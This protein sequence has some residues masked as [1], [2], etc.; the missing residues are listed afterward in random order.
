M[1]CGGGQ[2]VSVLVYYSN[3]PS[4]NPADA[5]SYVCVKIVFEKNENKQKRGRG[6]PNFYK[7]I[8]AFD[9]HG[10]ILLRIFSVQIYAVLILR[11]LIVWK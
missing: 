10:P 6:W 11:V 5:Y 3:N 9:D 2:K 7:K 8:A 4:L 1:G